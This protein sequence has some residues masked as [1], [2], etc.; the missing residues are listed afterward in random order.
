LGCFYR[1]FDIAVAG[2]DDHDGPVAERHFLNARKHFQS[3]DA[4]QPDIEKSQFELAA[5]QRRKTRF[6][7]FHGANGIAFVLQHATEGLA[8]ARLVVHHQNAAALHTRT[9]F[10]TAGAGS[11]AS[12]SAGIS[13]MNRAPMGRLSSTRMDAL[14][15]ATMWLTIARPRPVPRFLV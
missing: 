11:S 13:I 5:G 6:A 15:S 14:C 10:E 4:R 3:V 9:A 1:R 2:N 12:S 7:A 8:D